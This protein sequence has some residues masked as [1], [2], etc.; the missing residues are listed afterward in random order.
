MQSMVEGACER[1]GPLRLAP[2][3]HLRR[4][5]GEEPT[6][7]GQP[8]SW[9]LGVEREIASSSSFMSAPISPKSGVLR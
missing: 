9:A 4:G 6:G 2:L 5:A 7:R 8:G 3:R 1:T